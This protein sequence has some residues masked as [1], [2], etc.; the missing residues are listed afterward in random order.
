MH[1]SDM[2]RILLGFALGIIVAS[3]LSM[4]VKIAFWLIIAA[5]VFVIALAIKRW[6][7]KKFSLWG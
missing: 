5:T 2:D 1:L 6:V 3:M 4:V 7:E